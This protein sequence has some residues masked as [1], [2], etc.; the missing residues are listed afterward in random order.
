MLGIYLADNALNGIMHTILNSTNILREFH[1]SAEILNTWFVGIKMF[2]LLFI[3]IRCS[4]F[5]CDY[6]DL[7]LNYAPVHSFKEV[8]MLLLLFVE[9]QIT[10]EK[11]VVV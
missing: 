3:Y 1:Y 7:F 6:K 2:L 8:V 4:F 11:S 10:V 5:F 9:K